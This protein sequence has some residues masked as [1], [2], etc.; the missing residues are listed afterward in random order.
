MTRMA[1]DEAVALA[2]RHHQ[3]GDIRRAIDIY[4][5]VLAHQP[6]HPQALQFLGVAMLQDGSRADAVALLERA[7]SVTPNDADIRSNLGQAYRAAKRFDAA[8]AAFRDA[9]RL[10]PRSHVAYDNLGLLLEDTGRPAHA[11]ESF[12]RATALA[13]GNADV[14]AHLA[15]ALFKLNEL[16]ECVA[17]AD[18]ALQINPDHVIALT[19]A[20]TGLA[21]LNRPTAAIDRLNRAL[22]RDPNSYPALVSLARAS[23]LLGR[24]AD[25]VDA[26]QRAVVAGAR[27]SDQAM[28]HSLLLLLHALPDQTPQ[29]IAEAHQ[30]WAAAYADPISTM[31]VPP[32]QSPR[33]NGR[34]LRIGY[35]SPDFHTHAVA[36][37]VLPLLEAHDRTR[38]EIFGYCAGRQRDDV[39]GRVRAACDHWRDIGDIDDLPADAAAEQIRD[40]GIDILVDLAGHTACNRLDVFARRPAPVQVT[41]C[42]YPGS[43]GMRAMDY[44]ITDAVA[45]PP[46]VT[47]HLHSERLIRL[48]H[49][50][51]CYAPPPN[52]PD[53][54][55]LPRDVNGYVTFGSFNR[56]VKITPAAIDAWCRIL[57]AVPDSRLLLKLAGLDEPATRTDWLARFGSRGVS[58]DRI[59]TRDARSPLADYLTAIGSVDVALDTFP[60]NGTTTTCE[61]LWMGVPV[62]TLA[63][64]SHVSRVGTSLLHSV[65]LEDLVAGTVDEYVGKA[66]A[67]ATDPSRL[68][69]LRQNLRE[70]MRRSPLT[71]AKRLA[72]E[73]EDAF[74]AM[75]PDYGCGTPG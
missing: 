73:I 53:V 31:A 45:D 62:V 8:E 3:A 16:G 26:H 24:H 7:A 48:P 12:E 11:A 57:T 17:T 52:A 50:F 32:V 36:F 34:R 42:G 75:M 35:V 46:S 6:D 4:R 65:D 28:R 5:Q 19:V 51:L 56:A 18:A 58:A 71:D 61:A 44:R 21:Y 49:G 69:N 2:L 37:F 13:P 43:T 39:T 47:E 67:L 64:Q 1:A 9:I 30:A 29:Q 38:F 55:P 63:G 15:R 33:G 23:E 70:M 74:V 20:G 27:S 22:A 10:D 60:Y 25:A 66:V 41:Y 54:A 59:L 14:L 68:R 40:D 72:R